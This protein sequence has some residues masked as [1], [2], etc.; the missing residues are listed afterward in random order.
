[1]SQL[2]ASTHTGTISNHHF[3]REEKTDLKGEVVC[4]RAHNQQRQEPQAPKPVLLPALLLEAGAGKEKER[5]RA[6]LDERRG[7]R[8]RSVYSSPTLN[9]IC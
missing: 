1:L 6:C 5:G 4:L 8:M 7:P 9:A 2:V 3:I